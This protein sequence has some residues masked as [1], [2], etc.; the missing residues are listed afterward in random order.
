MVRMRHPKLPPEQVYDA[1]DSQVPSLKGSG[2]EVISDD[3]PG[4]GPPP[5]TE[6]QDAKAPADAGAFS[7]PD[8]DDTPSKRRRATKEGG[9]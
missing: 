2:W 8:S 1:M 6:P 5:T 9:E 3:P 4:D 7:L